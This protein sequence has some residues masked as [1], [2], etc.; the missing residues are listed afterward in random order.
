MRLKGYSSKLLMLTF[1]SVLLA[2]AVPSI[3]DHGWGPPP[4]YYHWARMDAPLQ[5][6]VTD[7]VSSLWDTE[8]A[9]VLAKWNDSGVMIN[10]VTA[11]DDAKK[12]RR[13]CQSISGKI[14]VCNESYGYNGWAGLASINIENV[15]GH[16]HIIR[17]TAEMNDTYGPYSQDF[18]YHVM[19]QE[20]GHL[21]GLGHTSEDGSSQKT[22]MDYS[23]DPASQFP[24]SH[25][26]AL[27]ANIYTHLDVYDSIAA[28]DT[29]GGGTKPCRGRNCRNFDA[30]DVPPMGVRVHANDHHE[31]WVARGRGDS[32]WI[33]HVTLVPE[34][35]RR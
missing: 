16:S 18:K 13:R 4:N 12:T 34:A 29:G 9:E 20:V 27:L 2:T 8:L 23:N 5:L 3:A 7:S 28:T 1:A 15:D 6:Q 32:L 19:C 17:G 25:D 14:R 21:Y 11:S 26:Y 31:I 22:C 24:N 30:P 33:H 10:A 35:Y